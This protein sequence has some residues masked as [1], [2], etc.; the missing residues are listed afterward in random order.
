MKKIETKG[1]DKKQKTMKMEKKRRIVKL[2]A[3]DKELLS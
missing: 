3:I 2:I 1:R